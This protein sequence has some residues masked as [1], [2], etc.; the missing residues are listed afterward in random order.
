MAC[1][2]P[3]EKPAAKDLD[4]A[5]ESFLCKRPAFFNQCHRLTL[6]ADEPVCDSGQLVA[7]L[8]ISSCG[9]LE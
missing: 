8:V 6:T 2:K 3:Q 7:E 4:I 5:C 9:L 1:T